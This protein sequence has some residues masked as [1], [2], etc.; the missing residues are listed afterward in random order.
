MGRA[1]G[2]LAHGLVISASHHVCWLG[3]LRYHNRLLRG[4]GE[5][6]GVKGHKR[7]HPSHPLLRLNAALAPR[8]LWGSTDASIHPWLNNRRGASQCWEGSRITVEVS[9]ASW[10]GC[11]R[12]NCWLGAVGEEAEGDTDHGGGNRQSRAQSGG[13]SVAGS[14]L[15]KY[16]APKQRGGYDDP[17]NG[18][19]RSTL[20]YTGGGWFPRRQKLSHPSSYPACR[21]PLARQ[22]IFRLPRGARSG[23]Y[24]T[25]EA[26]LPLSAVLWAWT[27]Q[28]RP[29]LA[30]RTTAAS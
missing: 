18:W 11:P 1:A 12:R 26:I 16:A 13:F 19:E 28:A 30:A 8:K 9:A 6:D 5:N 10:L 23:T 14:R 27:T 29:G 2:T 24:L 7:A 25:I 15:G 4:A 3:R 20:R 17:G 21:S 22:H